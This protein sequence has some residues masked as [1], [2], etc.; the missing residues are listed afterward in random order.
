MFSAADLIDALRRRG[1]RTLRPDTPAGEFPPGW[2]QWFEAI[3]QR[4]GRI[5]GATAEAIV[6]VFLQRE[7]A[8]PPRSTAELNR[9]Q[10][11]A[12][13]WRQQWLPP[14][15]EDRRARAT[16][17][18]ITVF[19]HLVLVVLLL[20]LASVHFVPPAAPAGEDVVQVEFIGEGTPRDQG[21]GP[22]AGAATTPSAAVARAVPPPAAAATANPTAQP[23]A[24]TPPAESATSQTPVAE[25]P[26]QVSDKPVPEAAFALPPPTPRIVEL[27]QAPRA[28]PRLQAPVRDIELVKA[29]P[30]VQPLQPRLP[31][32][33]AAVPQLRTTPQ[34]IEIVRPLPA[35]KPLEAIAVQPVPTQAPALR[36]APAE[37]PLHETAEQPVASAV[38]TRPSTASSASTPNPS[39]PTTAAAPSGTPAAPSG[40]QQATTATGRGPASSAKP[41][42]WPT[43]RQGDD[44]GASKRERPGGLAG[45]TPGVLNSDGT[46]RLGAGTA[47]AG[48]GYPPGADN[49]T[50]DQIDRSGT[51][52]KRP[53]NSYEPT[54]FDRV[55]VPNETLLEQWVRQNIRSMDIPIPGTTK[56]L[57]C[58]VSLLQLGGGCGITDPDMQDQEATARPPPD[59]P[60][61]PDL[62][63]DQDALRKP[64]AP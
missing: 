48:G 50:M 45:S 17:I 35:V 9:W 22:P 53:S 51:W 33:A 49:W 46:P 28:E 2:T 44:W 27:P 43:P 1:R 57:H 10:A 31:D 30:Q 26:L 59:V 37:V 62:Q 61:K 32:T 58:V 6:A 47:Q 14:E 56:K 29:L 15:R 36:E 11:F 60:F 54:R 52:L 19:V 40:T 13:L 3:G 4:I 12:T 18:A 20:W 24:P 64:A 21:G 25:Q 38:A 63:D 39:V 23:P 7:P 42:T 5:T 41:G 16:A 55:W 8:P 34:A